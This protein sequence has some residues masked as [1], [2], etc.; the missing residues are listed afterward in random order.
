MKSDI[1]KTRRQ[2]A[3]RFGPFCLSSSRKHLNDFPFGSHQLLG[4]LVVPAH[5]LLSILR[6]LSTEYNITLLKPDEETN[7]AATLASIPDHEL[8]PVQMIELFETL[9]VADPSSSATATSTGSSVPSSASSSSDDLALDI[10]ESDAA[11]F[12]GERNGIVVEN[13]RVTSPGSIFDIRER[14]SPLDVTP[15]AALKKRPRRLRGRSETNFASLPGAD[16]N[17]VSRSSRVR[18]N[19]NIDC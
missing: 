1:T 12:F 13:N 6:S 9:S 19:S 2:L 3:P 16:N 5:A 10:D 4:E 11:E 17:P 7:L 8:T 15:S 18:L 14:S